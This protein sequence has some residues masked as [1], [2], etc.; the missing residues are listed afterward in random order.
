MVY[1]LTPIILNSFTILY[2]S[3]ACHLF[4]CAGQQKRCAND[5]VINTARH[6]FRSHS[7]LWGICFFMSQCIH[8][9]NYHVKHKL[10]GKWPYHGT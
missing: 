10:H 8:S 1:R 9:L 7:V 2:R 3:R 5:F 6:S 4:L